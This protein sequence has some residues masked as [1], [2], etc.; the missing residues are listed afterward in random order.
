MPD[1]PFVSA[2]DL[3]AS[4][5]EGI[6]KAPPSVSWSVGS[7]FDHVEVGPQRILLLGGAPGVGK[8]ALVMQ[9]V[10]DAL[11]GHPDLRVVIANVEMSPWRLLER[12]L[13]RLSG[14]P[15]T[16]IRKRQLGPDDTAML[17]LGFDRI[18]RVSHR[19]AFLTGPNQLDRIGDAADDHAAD[20]I[21]LDHVQ[22]ITPRGSYGSMRDQINVLMGQLRAIAT[23]GFGVIAV[24]ALTRSKDDQ[25]RSS[26]AGQYLSMAS[27]R[28]SSE[29]E[30][31]ADDCFL[32]FPSS[33][34][35]NLS[36]GPLQSHD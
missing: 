20:L 28:E 30:Y 31:G 13:A 5:R 12:Q 27:Y 2:A 22:R 16:D 14:V 19:L 10:F 25:G 1:C 4:W 29:L 33:S 11:A 32:L 15:L 3:F 7:G 26:Y 24:A 8:T 18:S 9:W 21:V 23:A 36:S 17:E 35:T 34:N 6:E